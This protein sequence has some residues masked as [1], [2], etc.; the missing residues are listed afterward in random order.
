MRAR[1]LAYQEVE[2]VTSGRPRKIYFPLEG[3]FV[4]SHNL[5]LQSWLAGEYQPGSFTD[6][7]AAQIEKQQQENSSNKMTR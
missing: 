7:Y 5:A 2:E 4:S 6:R 3:I 1:V